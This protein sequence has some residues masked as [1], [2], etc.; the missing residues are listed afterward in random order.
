MHS[1]GPS[2]ELTLCGCSRLVQGLSECL[3]GTI[4]TVLE[5]L[6]L[7]AEAIQQKTGAN[8]D[9]VQHLEQIGNELRQVGAFLCFHNEYEANA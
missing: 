4:R 9:F 7:S 6:T 5:N 3:E 2:E 8:L 1:T